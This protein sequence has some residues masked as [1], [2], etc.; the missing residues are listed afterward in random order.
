MEESRKAL[1]EKLSA[2]YRDAAVDTNALM[3][4]LEGAHGKLLH[5]VEALERQAV[6]PTSAVDDDAIWRAVLDLFDGRT[7]TPYDDKAVEE[8]CKVA[9]TRFAVGR[10]PGYADQEK[11][12]TAQYGDYILWQQ[13]LDRAKAT[14]LPVIFVTDDRKDDWWLKS[15]GRT[16]GPRPELV[17]EMLQEAGVDFWMYQPDQFM[18]YASE[19]YK[20]DVS[21]E[22][23]QE[24][25]SLPSRSQHVDVAERIHPPDTD[26]TWRIVRRNR[27][28]TLRRIA[29]TRTELA[30]VEELS[31]GELSPGQRAYLHE[32]RRDLLGEMA[33]LER[34]MADSEQLAESLRQRRPEPARIGRSIRARQTQ[35]VDDAEQEE[36]PQFADDGGD[37]S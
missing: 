29:E 26:A 14:S 33:M 37:G 22:T 17:S 3:A 21:P 20:T 5:E 30:R 28:S 36:L 34:R 35:W 10:P 23:L 24:V 8:L 19:R 11:G 6:E 18:T 12:G 13:I 27:S 9:E 7:G 25:R 32:R 4:G 2:L 16:V 15:H 1:Q 31:A